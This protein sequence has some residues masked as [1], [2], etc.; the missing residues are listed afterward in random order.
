MSIYK[1]KLRAGFQHFILSLVAG[2]VVLGLVYFFWFPGVFSKTQ[3]IGTILLIMLGIDIVAGPFLTA[4][5]YKRGK[6]SLKFDLSVIA[7]CQLAFL[8]YGLQAVYLGRPAFIVFAKDRFEPVSLTEFNQTDLKAARQQNNLYAE[9]K[10]FSPSY[11]AVV[12]PSDPKLRDELMFKAIDGGPDLPQM[13]QYFID[14]KLEA[15]SVKKRA[16][17]LDELILLNPTERDSIL[18]TAKSLAENNSITIA[19]IGF[20]PFKGKSQDA[21]V[22]VNKKT[23]TVL[24][25][26]LFQPWK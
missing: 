26:F 13:P 18:K 15:G 14:Y 8:F 11:V 9:S 6:A 22:F 1:D 7:I 23:A 10:F 2:L 4:V 24:G 19:D 16:M 12:G 25:V 20:L 5:V 21:S 17:S 3:S